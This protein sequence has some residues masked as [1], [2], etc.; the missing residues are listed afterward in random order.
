MVEISVK[1][2]KNYFYA[3]IEE[4]SKTE[5]YTRLLIMNII[6]FPEIR[7]DLEN[8]NN[9]Y[10]DLFDIGIKEIE[11]KKTNNFC[12]LSYNVIFYVDTKF[13]VR[14]KKEEYKYLNNCKLLDKMLLDQ[15]N[16]SDYYEIGIV[17]DLRIKSDDYEFKGNDKI[18]LYLLLDSNLA[19]TKLTKNLYRYGTHLDLYNQYVFLSYENFKRLIDSNIHIYSWSVDSIIVKC[20]S[21]VQFK[22]LV[23]I[24]M[25]KSYMLDNNINYEISLEFKERLELKKLIVQL[26][27]LLN[28]CINFKKYNMDSDLPSIDLMIPIEMDYHNQEFKTCLKYESKINDLTKSLNSYNIKLFFR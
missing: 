22:N 5:Y 20:E 23:Y 26:N 7:V 15:K 11:I 18:D 27:Y 19:S 8:L 17:F 13:L 4:F 10:L 3:F 12:K 28:E 1:T 24:F 6:E 25:H 2:L 9:D 14:A 21:I 16:Q